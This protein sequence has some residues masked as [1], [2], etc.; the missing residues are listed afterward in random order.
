MESHVELCNK[1]GIPWT[2]NLALFYLQVTKFNYFL[3]FFTKDG[4]TT[5]GISIPILTIISISKLFTFFHQKQQPFQLYFFK[6]KGFIM[7]QSTYW[8]SSPCSLGIFEFN[9]NDYHLILPWAW[10]GP[11]LATRL[12]SWP[13]LRSRSW[14]WSGLRTWMR[15]VHLLF[16]HSS[17]LIHSILLI[18]LFWGLRFTFFWAAGTALASR[19]WPWTRAGAWVAA[20]PGGQVFP[21]LYCRHLFPKST[22]ICQLLHLTFFLGVICPWL[23]W[24]A[25]LFCA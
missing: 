18:L 20:R 23:Q 24:A 4:K 2:I 3:N 15:S 25:L 11:G 6:I 12:R 21:M 7:L 1:I 5:E 16:L 9:H 8:C 13:R 22:V 19:V 10:P 14:T 17:C